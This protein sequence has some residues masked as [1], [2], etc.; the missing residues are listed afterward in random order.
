MVAP[1]S[2]VPPEYPVGLS[3]EAPERIARWRP[4]VQWLLA[5]PHYFVLYALG[6]VSGVL[7]LVS[8]FVILFTGRLPAGIA[9]FQAMYL[10]YR[11]RVTTYAGFLQEE[12]P[13]FSFTA[14]SPD[15]A[16]YPHLRVDVD[17]ALEDRNRLTTFFR[18]LLAI[19]QLV[20]LFFLGIAASVVWLIA[21]F[22]VL[23]TGYWSEGLGNFAV[24][25]LRW[26]LR[27]EAYLNLLTDR[28]PPFSLGGGATGTAGAPTLRPTTPGWSATGD[29]KPA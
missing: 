13:P 8:W 1:N 5:L 7:V 22:V 24:G 12:Y 15:P 3:F 26:N 10:R 9:N 28:Y 16:T 25:Y 11:V 18:L 2:P 17:P 29:V 19:P 6:I 14:V 20:V 27:V 21:F 23:V 4:L